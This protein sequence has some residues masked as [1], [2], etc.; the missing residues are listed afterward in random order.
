MILKTRAK[1]ALFLSFI[2]LVAMPQCVYAFGRNKE[3][4]TNDLAVTAESNTNRIFSA[5]VSEY[6]VGARKMGKEQI[7]LLKDSGIIRLAFMVEKNDW[8]QQTGFQSYLKATIDYCK[9]RG[10]ETVIVLKSEEYRSHGWYVLGRQS[11]IDAWIA[12]GVD[13]IR[14]CDPT[15]VHIMDEP[16]GY[17]KPDGYRIT[18]ARFYNDFLMPSYRAYVREKPDIW[19]YVTSCPWYD[20]SHLETVEFP[21]R[22]IVQWHI[23]Y[24]DNAQ[25][26][27]IYE[28]YGSGD[29]Q[30]GKKQLYDLLDSR[31]GSLKTEKF[32]LGSGANR[33]PWKPETN[34]EQFMKDIYA[35]VNENGI[36]EYWQ[37][38][39]GV[40]YWNIL[41]APDYESFTYAG[42]VYVDHV[43]QTEKNVWDPR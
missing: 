32:V 3:F 38:T 1:Q 13:M 25:L 19:V 6:F 29:F 14:K 43:K 11:K 27:R 9:Q 16:T 5:W 4:P 21:E 17:I 41:E 30:N 37:W 2:L 7:D 20:T 39:I 35:Y 10:I 34:F 15:G 26:G 22:A 23:F 12:W 8:Y 24:R 40:R 28:L 42:Q 36:K 33:Y 31:L 18:F